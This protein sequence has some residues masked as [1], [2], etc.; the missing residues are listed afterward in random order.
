[1]RSES[2]QGWQPVLLAE[3]IDQGGLLVSDGY[4]AKNAELGERGLPFARAGNIRDG[5]RLEEADLL[6]PQSVERAGA[7]IAMP[8]DVV[9]TSK[10]T[11]G[12]F[13]FV[14][15]STPTFVYSPQLCFWRALDRTM[16]EPRFLF[17]WMQGHECSRQFDS[18]KG[19]TDMADYIS[20]RDQRT[21]WISL[22]PVDE[23]RQIAAVLGALDD[24]IDSNRR[25]A[26]LLEQAAAEL[27]RAWF[28][29]FV[30]VEEFEDS[31]IGRI[32]RGWWCGVLS[33]VVEVTMG[34]SP[35]GA[36]Y[37][38]DP[39]AGLLLVQG[40]G[41]LGVRY[42]TSAVYTVAPTRRARA[43]D[44]LMTVRAPVGSVNVARTDV[45]LGRG[46]AGI[47]SESPAF[48]EFLIRALTSRW[49]SE[50]SGT[51]F[52]AVNRAQV[53]GLRIV[54]PPPA[55]IAEFEALATPLVNNLTTLHDET[56]SL[57]RVRDALLPKLIS[58]AIRVPDKSD[59]AEAIERVREQLAPTQR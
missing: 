5:F 11:V 55:M 43:G 15:P 24:K 1:M 45:C 47:A 56:E 3:L 32:P 31:E 12:R 40:M 38:D 28:V 22:P 29:D 35:P 42:P 46:V 37:T 20:L 23:Q 13:A 51:I 4:R 39:D 10:G 44:T 25:L 30:G 57:V 21:I 8:D 50:E 41:G 48:A 2:S 36:S 6:A 9:F 34:Q 53:L 16:V 54:V 33:D 18:L 7:K 59:P 26:A 17:F 27:F 52:P 58:G 19:Q 14:R 49:A